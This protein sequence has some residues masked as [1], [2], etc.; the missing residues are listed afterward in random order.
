M[1][2]SHS[3]QRECH[4]VQ[5]IW[6]RHGKATPELLATSQTYC[7]VNAAKV[8]MRQKYPRGKPGGTTEAMQPSSLYRG[9]GYIFFWF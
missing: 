5:G 9:V 8:A 6:L 7:G 1:S 4:Q 3:L 2:F